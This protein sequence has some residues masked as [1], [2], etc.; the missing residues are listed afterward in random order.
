MCCVYEEKKKEERAPGCIIVHCRLMCVCVCSGGLVSGLQE[1]EKGVYT[2]VQRA[3][4]EATQW[5]MPH[6]NRKGIFCSSSE[7]TQ[8][9]TQRLRREPEVE[10]WALKKKKKKDTHTH[11]HTHTHT[12]RPSKANSLQCIAKSQ[13]KKKKKEKRRSDKLKMSLLCKNLYQIA[14]FVITVIGAL[15]PPQ[16]SGAQRYDLLWFGSSRYH[17]RVSSSEGGRLGGRQGGR[18]WSPPQL[19]PTP[20]PP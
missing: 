6:A 8:E 20:T 14:P 19:A 3:L 4:A 13:S 18:V 7:G 11:T 12:Q 15:T 10:C 16:Q 2:R 17:P 9:V 5:R 1:C